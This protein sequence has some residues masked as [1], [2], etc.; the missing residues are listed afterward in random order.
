MGGLAVIYAVLNALATRFTPLPRFA[1]AAGGRAVTASPDRPYALRAVCNSFWIWPLRGF[2]HP[3]PDPPPLRRGGGFKLQTL[4]KGCLQ[5]SV[6]QWFRPQV[7]LA[8]NGRNPTIS[9]LG[10]GA[11]A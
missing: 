6:T 3:L 4:P 1:V 5:L 9:T 2:S 8:R 10:Y 11:S 7:G